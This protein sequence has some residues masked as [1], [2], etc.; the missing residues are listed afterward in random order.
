VI[1]TIKKN[2]KEYNLHP[3][4]DVVKGYI[5]YVAGNILHHVGMYYYLS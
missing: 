2:K 3:V 4:L 5:N 1:G